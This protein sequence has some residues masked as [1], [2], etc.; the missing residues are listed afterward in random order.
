[1][2]RC[3][4]EARKQNKQAAT[5]EPYNLW[6]SCRVNHFVVFYLNST[7]VCFPMQEFRPT[8]TINSIITGLLKNKNLKTDWRNAPSIGYLPA[9]Q[10]G[11]AAWLP[12]CCEWQHSPQLNSDERVEI[13]F[14]ERIVIFHDL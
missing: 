13:W 11:D 10:V 3:C 2:A 7:F 14:G 9:S 4:F 8:R 12:D 6:R 1:M 5:S